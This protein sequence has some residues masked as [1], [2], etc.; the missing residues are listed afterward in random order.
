MALRDALDA[1]SD[2]LGERLSR[3]KPD[4]EAHGR[5]ESHFGLTPPD[6]VAWPETTAE[7][8][9]IVRIC[10][11]HGVPVVGWGAGTSLEGHAL[12]VRGG[13]AVDFARMNRVLDVRP[14]DMDVTVQPGLTRR[15]LE[16]ELRATGLF[17]PVDPGADAS[18]GGMAATRA[19]GT[20]TVRYGSMRDNVLGL[21][22]VLADGRV[23]R[24]GSRARKSAA[25]Y[26]LTALMLGS[27]GTL[28]LITELTLRLHGRP[29]AVAA[30]I[31]AFPG[32]GGAVDCVIE[33]I[34]MGLPMARIEFVD[35]ASAA[36]FNAHAGT[37]LPERPHLLVELHGSETGVAEQA[38]LFGALVA[39][40][41][42]DPFEWST[43]EEERRHLWRMRHNGYY[44]IMAAHPGRA[45]AGDRHLRA[46]LA[47]GRGGGGDAD[48]HRGKRD[49]WP[50]P[51]PCGRR[52]LPRHADRAARSCG[53]SRNREGSR[54][55]DGRAGASA[56]R[57]RDGRA[58]GGHGQ[59]RLH[60]RGA[61]RGLGGHGRDQGGARPA[62]HPQPRQAGAG[63]LSAAP[64]GVRPPATAGSRP[65][66]G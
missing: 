50:D 19:S 44:A 62:G 8:Q 24:T 5:S 36:A 56:G 12:A 31:A 63:Q 29:E 30:G 28:G 49:A 46:D 1:L 11:R 47:A 66:T 54:A 39:E 57:H 37:D 59:D 60:G 43:R 20:T 26:D 40:H 64:S 16:E 3:S 2:L 42:G 21:E 27:E 58:R 35:A 6:A 45:G 33:T 34:Q 7:V 18:L 9:Q 25:G 13:V 10:A 41:G 14:E 22:V 23:I 38:E 52:Q 61:W 53:R 51:G 55:P 32:I 4:L 17:F 65:R 48:R 15:A